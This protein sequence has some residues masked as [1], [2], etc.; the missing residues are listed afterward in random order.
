MRQ[1]T[2]GPKPD[3]GVGFGSKPQV[4]TLSLLSVPF[5]LSCFAFL[6]TSDQGGTGAGRAAVVKE[7]GTLPRCLSGRLAGPLAGVLR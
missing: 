2:Y 1:K 4:G 5:P 6:P 3:C 7:P